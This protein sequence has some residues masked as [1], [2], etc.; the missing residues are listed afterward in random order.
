MNLV[1]SCVVLHD[2]ACLRPH[3]SSYTLM[4]LQVREPAA[5]AVGSGPKRIS[6]LGQSINSGVAHARPQHEHTH[7]RADSAAVPPPRSPSLVQPS[8]RLASRIASRQG[9]SAGPSAD[10]FASALSQQGVPGPSKSA[11]P[12]PRRSQQI[13][14]A[15]GSSQSLYS[16][17]V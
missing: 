5:A 8:P 13:S 17:K 14:K 10:V 12:S 4:W 7:G 6:C 2:I 16:S 11:A 15:G 1:W 9:L 3:V